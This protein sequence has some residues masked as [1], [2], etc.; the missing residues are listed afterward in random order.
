[1][2][3]AILALFVV[4]CVFTHGGAASAAPEDRG[5]YSCTRYS[6]AIP[7]RNSGTITALVFKTGAGGK[8]PLIVFRHG[9]LRTGQ[10]LAACGEHWASRGCS[11]ILNDARSGIPPDYTGIDSD[12]MIDC[13]DWAVQKGSKP[14][15]YLHGAVD[16][17]AVVIG[18]FS[19]GGYTALI[20]THKNCALG[21]GNFRCA[22]MVLYDPYPVDAEHAV[23]LAR[24][25]EVPA[26]MLHAD[27]AACNGRGRGKVI[28]PNTAGPTYAIH[29]RDASHCDFE[30]QASFGCNL[31]C[32]GAWDRERNTAIRRYATA[33]IEAYAG[34]NARAYPYIN[35]TIALDDERITVYPE[36]RGLDLPQKPMPAQLNKEPGNRQ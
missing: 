14:G 36:T 24:E 32:A 21:D 33:M 28:Y 27:D 29:V 13:A 18:G 17:T 10:S 15:H 20:A 16:S 11:V 8:R 6:E 1:M 23:G 3:K 12:D 2:K 19:A 5:P 7:A 22:C 35:G 25:I 4:T 31:L 34:K 9:F 26:I 30:P